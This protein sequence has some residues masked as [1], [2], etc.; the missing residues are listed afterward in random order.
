[1]WIDPRQMPT[2]INTPHLIP[3]A[4]TETAPEVPDFLIP[5]ALFG[6]RVESFKNGLSFTITISAVGFETQQTDR[7]IVYVEGVLTNISNQPIVVHKTLS[8]GQTENY[9]IWDIFYNGKKIGNY[10]CCSFLSTIS[11]DDFVV[12]QPN[13]FQTYLLGLELPFE[14]SDDEGHKTALSKKNIQLTA[15][16]RAFDAGYTDLAVFPR[17]YIDMNA[18]VGVVESNSV[19]YIFP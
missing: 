18:W 6:E 17:R 4:L 2:P 15:T 12:L 16:Y 7:Y 10:L 8:T 3:T 1:V 13:E 9:V 5:T 14:L 19:E 11:A